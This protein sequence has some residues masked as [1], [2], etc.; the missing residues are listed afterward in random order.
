MSRAKIGLA[1]G[2]GAA[3]GW[4]HIGILEGLAAM[5]IVPDIVCGTSIGALVGAAFCGGR[6]DAL[7]TRVSGLGWREIAGLLDLRLAGGGLI[8][9]RR[10]ETFLSDTGIGGDIQAMTPRFAAVATDLASGAEVW[11]E[12]GPVGPAVRASIGMPGVFNPLWDEGGQRWLIDGGLVNPV[13]VSLARALGAEVVI[14]VDLNGGLLG[15][16]FARDTRRIQ[17]V[18]LLQPLPQGLRQRLSPL[19]ERLL[20]SGSTP[21]YFDVLANALNIMQDRI[22]R[23]RL[24]GEPPDV[25]LQPN[26]GQLSWMDFHRARDAIAEGR[27]TVERCAAMLAPYTASAQ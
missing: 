8:E 19:A 25:L 15:R 18:A 13:P 11:F 10:I 14:A 23:A 4:A 2:S 24:A 9:G 3:R 26:L 16:R 5:G 20:A 17:A 1:L 22:T 27:V 12:E 7:K 6:L 21:S